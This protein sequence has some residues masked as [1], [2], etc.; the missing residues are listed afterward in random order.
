[1][2]ERQTIDRGWYYLIEP[3]DG[4]W[5]SGTETSLAGDGRLQ[6]TL[7]GISL[8]CCPSHHP[9]ETQLVERLTD[10]E[11]S[12]RTLPLDPGGLP[13]RP[14]LADARPAES[15]DSHRHRGA[16]V[17]RAVGARG[18]GV[19]RWAGPAPGGLVTGRDRSGS[20]DTTGPR[21]GGQAW[22]DRS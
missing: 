22:G 6:V 9:I 12:A 1:M 10:V 20:K 14:G 16:P 4:E 11:V 13:E 3:D 18:S 5:A 17:L 7:D 15:A 21:H 19:G 2:N 8:A